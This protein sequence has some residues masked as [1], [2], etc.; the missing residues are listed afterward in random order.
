MGPSDLMVASDPFWMV[1]SDPPTKFKGVI[2]SSQK[3][4]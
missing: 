2:F 4:F 3:D 1:A